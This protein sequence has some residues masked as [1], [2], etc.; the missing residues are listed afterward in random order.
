MNRGGSVSYRYRNG[1][2]LAHAAM[3]Q[4]RPIEVEYPGRRPD[5]RGELYALPVQSSRPKKKRMSRGLLVYLIFAGCVVLGMTVFYLMREERVATASAAC[6]QLDR[7]ISTLEVNY[8]AART[9]FEC[10]T[11]IVSV[12]AI[13]SEKLNMGYGTN[14]QIRHMDYSKTDILQTT[15][16]SVTMTGD[17]LTGADASAMGESL[18]ASS[19]VS[20]VILPEVTDGDASETW[21][22]GADESEA[23]EGYIE[24]SGIIIPVEASGEGLEETAEEGQYENPLTEEAY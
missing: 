5:T 2:P 8:A 14:D 19:G 17:G 6:T 23:Y 20:D 15:L 21:P 9:Q 13:A 11:D 1:D 7:E 4:P 18:M 22:E 16:P 10:S 12:R 3:A 24:E